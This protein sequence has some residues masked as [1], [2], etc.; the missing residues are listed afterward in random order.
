MKF[1]KLP[2]LILLSCFS[3]LWLIGCADHEPDQVGQGSP[4]SGPVFAQSLE[5]T[6]PEAVS[7]VYSRSCRACHG[8][9]GHGIAAVAPDLRRA[10]PRSFEQWKT[11]LTNP[12]TG[13]PGAEM[14]PPT[15]IN[16]DEIEVMANYLVS[17]LPPPAVLAKEESKEAKPASRAPVLARKRAKR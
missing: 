4:N 12:Q 1:P 7:R 8:P 14:P 15:W 6:L 3:A 11:Y 9:E 10:K 13:H 2:K 5:P 16:T 17:L